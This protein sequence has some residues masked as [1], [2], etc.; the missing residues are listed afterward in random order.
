[1][2]VLY[3]QYFKRTSS[4]NCRLHT[5]KRNFTL[6][7]YN[8]PIFHLLMREFRK[9]VVVQPLTP[10]QT[11]LLQRT[12]LS[13][14]KVHRL[15][16]YCEHSRQKSPSPVDNFRGEIRKGP[17]EFLE[18]ITVSVFASCSQDKTYSPYTTPLCNA[19][20]MMWF[21]TSTCLVRQ[22]QK[23]SSPSLSSWIYEGVDWGHHELFCP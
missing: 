23:H 9:N 16:V 18:G 12:L 21:F 6:V 3:Y 15:N 13:P 10:E 2:T 22:L 8:Q 4:R 20:R 19:S 7:N 1:M 17:C 11:R 14:N 5:S